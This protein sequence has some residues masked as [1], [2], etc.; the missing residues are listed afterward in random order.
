MISIIHSSSIQ[1]PEEF[2]DPIMG[3]VMTDPVIL[4]S[5]G[6]TVDRSTIVR[7]LLRLLIVK[8]SY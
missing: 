7:H 8:S 6:N 3:T 2:I 5:S 4:P 1:A